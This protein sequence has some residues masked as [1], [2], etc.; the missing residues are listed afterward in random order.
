[1][2]AAVLTR[3]ANR[4]M[5]LDRRSLVSLLKPRRKAAPW[6]EENPRLSNGESFLISVHTEKPK[7]LERVVKMWPWLI[8]ITSVCSWRC[9]C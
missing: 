2:V 3:S 9:E 4:T 8:S 5:I 7:W 6:R 1:L